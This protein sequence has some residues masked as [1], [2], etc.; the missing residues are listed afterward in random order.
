MESA[1]VSLHSIHA[2]PLSTTGISFVLR[3]QAM[4]PPVGFKLNFT[5]IFMRHGIRSPSFASNWTDMKKLF[6]E[7]E[8]LNPDGIS[9]IGCLFTHQM[10]FFRVSELD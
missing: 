3:K 8:R 4:I 9:S 2:L 1:E 5:M 10:M 6:P 7:G